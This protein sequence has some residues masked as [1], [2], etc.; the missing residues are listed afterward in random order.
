MTYQRPALTSRSF[1]ALNVS[2]HTVGRGHWRSH[3]HHFTKGLP[4]AGHYARPRAGRR[5]EDSAAG[6]VLGLAKTG[7]TFQSSRFQVGVCIFLSKVH[8][9]LSTA[10][11]NLL[12]PCSFQVDDNKLTLLVGKHNKLIFYKIYL[13][14]ITRPVLQALRHR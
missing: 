4:P 14:G 11:R 7:A 13:T 12:L 5:D 3:T 10:L 6:S 1:P 9:T 8:L 2:V